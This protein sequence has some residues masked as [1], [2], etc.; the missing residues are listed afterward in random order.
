MHCSSL[1]SHFALLY[2]KIPYVQACAHFLQITLMT[3]C[4]I[5]V[6]SILRLVGSSSGTS[7]GHVQ[8]CRLGSIWDQSQSTD[9]MRHLIS[10][11]AIFVPG[12]L[13]FLGNSMYRSLS[14][15]TCVK[16]IMK[17]NCLVSKLLIVARFRKNL[18]APHDTTG[19]YV[20]L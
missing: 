13:K 18:V 16:A 8:G 20:S 14:I 12:L 9:P 3:A 6:C 10:A 5:Q 7:L 15:S 4:T 1:D 17:T 19:A 11:C 2:W